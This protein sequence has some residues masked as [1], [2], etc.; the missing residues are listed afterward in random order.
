M[1][2]L[3]SEQVA[4]TCKHFAAY[5][6]ENWHGMDRFHFNAVVSA[7]DMADTYLPAFEACVRHGHARS[8]MCSYNSVNGA[9]RSSFDL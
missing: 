1:Q 7:R 8:V 4:A 9:W 6:L 3:I 5:S 2:C